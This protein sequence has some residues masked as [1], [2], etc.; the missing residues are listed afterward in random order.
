VPPFLAEVAQYFSN[1]GKGNRENK[2]PKIFRNI[3]AYAAAD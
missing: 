1:K 2:R 3:G